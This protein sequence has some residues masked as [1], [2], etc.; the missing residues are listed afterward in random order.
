MCRGSQLRPIKDPLVTVYKP[1][2]LQSLMEGR[3]GFFAASVRLPTR[4]KQLS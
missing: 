1:E 2:R 3:L 4:V